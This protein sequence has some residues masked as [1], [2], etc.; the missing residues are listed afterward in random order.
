MEMWGK[1]KIED[2]EIKKTVLKITRKRT[3]NNKVTTIRL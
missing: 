3:V 1:R 2:E